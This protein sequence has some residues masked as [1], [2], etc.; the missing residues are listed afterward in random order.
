M[1]CVL[2]LAGCASS[3]PSEPLKVVEPAK[4]L[5][6]ECND[7]EFVARTGPGEITLYLP[8]ENL[9][10][11]KV[12]AASG[13]KYEGQGVVF[14]SKGDTATLDLGTRILGSCQLNAGRAPWEEARRRGVN[15]RA[16]GQEPGWYLELQHDQSGQLGS[17][18]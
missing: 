4:T 2:Y 5:V 8:T 11:E 9:V 1:L 7:F 13:E 16:V 18:G 14:Q 3:P 17:F 15:F 10:L 6:Y 12:R